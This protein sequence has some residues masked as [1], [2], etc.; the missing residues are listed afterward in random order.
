MTFET[1]CID[2]VG[3]IAIIG[4]AWLALPPKEKPS[5]PYYTFDK[6]SKPRI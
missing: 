5:K 6:D 3:I 4:A 1:V 2:L